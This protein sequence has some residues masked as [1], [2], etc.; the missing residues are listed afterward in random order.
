MIFFLLH[1]YG[2]LFLNRPLP[3]ALTMNDHLAVIPG[4]F[5]MCVG[6][7]NFW[8]TWWGSGGGAHSEGYGNMNND[9]FK[10][11]FYKL[12]CSVTYDFCFKL[13]LG[14]LINEIGGG[15]GR[16]T[17]QNT[18]YTDCHLVTAETN[19]PLLVKCTSCSGSCG[20]H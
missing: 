2:I 5:P 18:Q 12:H 7:A 10:V 17:L 4:L 19:L 13:K 3:D 8:N 15:G 11:N 20:L 16:S 6:G 14:S 9:I 1:F